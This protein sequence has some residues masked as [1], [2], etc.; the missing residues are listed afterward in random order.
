MFVM[1]FSF[2]SLLFFNVVI[3]GTAHSPQLRVQLTGVELKSDVYAWGSAF[4]SFS[5]E[6]Y[7]KYF[8]TRLPQ[9]DKFTVKGNAISQRVRAAAVHF[10][11]LYYKK[12]KSR[13]FLES[14]PHF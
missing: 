11:F 5:G 1:L 10:P 2:V 8:V 9:M 12:K 14:R 4:P 13:L 3:F 6:I 7:S